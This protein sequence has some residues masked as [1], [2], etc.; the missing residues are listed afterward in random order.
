MISTALHA[1]QHFSISASQQER[2]QRRPPKVKNSARKKTPQSAS[3][4]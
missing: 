4:R 3:S 2:P 1:F